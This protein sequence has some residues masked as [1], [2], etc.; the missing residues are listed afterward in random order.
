MSFSVSQAER[1]SILESL[2]S[3]DEEVRR[4]A[5]EQL[6]VLPLSEAADQLFECLGDTS[7]RVRKAAVARLVACGD[8]PVV[9]ELLVACL[10]DGENP[11]RRN[12]AYEALVGCGP[13]ATARLISEMSNSDGDV[14][15][16]LIDA[17]A[18]IGDPAACDHLVAAIDDPDANIRAAAVDAIGVVGDRQEIER[19]IEVASWRDEEVLVRLSA[20]R[21]L[22]RMEAEVAVARLTDALEHSLLR[23]AAFE[24]LGHS[25]DPS[26]DEALLKGLSAKGQ[27]SLESAMAALLRRLGRLDDLEAS[28]LRS[29]LRAA[30]ADGLID[31]SCQRLET[32]DLGHQLVLIQFLGLLED[33]RVVLP[34]LETGRDEAIAEVAAATLEPMG[35]AVSEALAPVWDDLDDG[36]KGRAC[37]ILGRIGGECAERLLATSLDSFN[38]Q[39]RCCAANAIGEGGFFGR[40][41]DLVRRLEAAAKNDDF[42]SEDEIGIL[43]AAIVRLA[44]RPEATRAGIDFELVEVLSS[45]LEGAPEP[46]RL[47]IAQVLA[48]LGREQDEDV[49]GYLLKD[50]SAVVR[51]AAVGALV[52]YDFETTRELLRIALADE[53]T[54]VRTE[55][56][57]VLGASGR[58]EAVSELRQ[59]TKDDDPKVVAVA[60]RSLG[61]LFAESEAESDEI[62]ES[63]GAA[64]AAGPIV[65]LA[66]FDALREM[67]GE[68]AGALARGALSH[69]EPDVVRAAVACLGAHGLENDLIEIIPFAG[70][71]DWSVRAE[72][73]EVLSA[74]GLRKGLP[75]LL[76]RLELEDDAFVR[77]VV[78]RVIGRLEG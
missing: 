11:G 27:S 10:A 53:A 43:V 76:R 14:R 6:L 36:L 7:W 48:R 19:L 5:V 55:A 50:E 66:G 46:V 18:V 8:Q 9:Q 64:L 37:S 73:A 78:L 2:S 54:I 12:S 69:G 3:A 41:P 52:R 74:R 65:A 29:R 22:S 77:Q 47:A 59:L 21:A 13:R 39:L 15:K 57:R 71:A 61:R 44:E 38:G 45:R 24:L 30:A 56:A 60:V 28:D 72:V 33:S 58:S 40:V 70:H 63:I 1:A 51:R 16:L 31:E 68:R 35:E 34:I 23:P 62:Y 67:G 75:A 32:A 4:L 49:I 17:L 20:L 26:A 42:E 25:M